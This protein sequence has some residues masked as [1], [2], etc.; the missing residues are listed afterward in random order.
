[1]IAQPA[2]PGAAATPES[3]AK[4]T[5]VSNISYNETFVPTAAF[6]GEIAVVILLRA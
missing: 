5:K 3:A 1:M 2:T 4:L 6:Y